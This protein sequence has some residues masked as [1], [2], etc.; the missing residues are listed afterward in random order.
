MKST[1][2]YLITGLLTVLFVTC[3]TTQHATNGSETTGAPAFWESADS[4]TSTCNAALERTRNLQRQAR[5]ASEPNESS[6]LKPYNDM[7]ESFERTVGLAQ[8]VANVHPDERVRKLAEGCERNIKALATEVNLDRPLYDAVL[9]VPEEGLDAQAKRFRM[10]VLREFRLAGVDKDEP[11][12]KRLKEIQEELVKVGQSFDRNIREDVRSIKIDPADLAGLPEDFASNHKPG[13]DGKVT[14]TTNYPDYIPVQTYADKEEVRRKI[15]FEFLNRGHPKND[16]TL[17]RILILRNEQASLLGYPNWADYKA[18]DKMA[19]SAEAIQSFTEQVADI[20]RPRSKRDLE[21]LLAR[22]KKDDPKAKS[23]EAW[24]RFFYVGKVRSEEYGFDSQKVRPYFEYQNVRQGILDL[25][26][27]LFEVTFERREGMSVWDDSVEVFD[28]MLDGKQAGR[29]YLD[30]H[31]RKDKYGHAAMFPMVIGLPSR[32][33]PEAAL[34]CNFPDPKESPAGAPSWSTP[35][36]S[37][38]STSLD[39]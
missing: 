10:K 21:T 33:I 13:E 5:D 15:A 8:L 22:K 1:R 34:V 38:S 17:K 31:P 36:C 24:D 26:A 16:E 23:I 35:R 12:R 11:T 4:L 18:Q 9:A 20:A 39:T 19:R 14:I 3:T 32:Q 37:R 7:V 29:F 27:D 25:Y 2:L 30:M 28:M 6:V